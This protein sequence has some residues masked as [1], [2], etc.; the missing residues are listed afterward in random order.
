MI[1]CDFYHLCHDHVGEIVRK[2]FLHG[3]TWLGSFVCECSCPLLNCGTS[4]ASQDKDKE[5]NSFVFTVKAV[6]Q[7][8]TNEKA[9][10]YFRLWE[11]FPFYTKI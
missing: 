2:I 10:V 4:L 7:Q 8:A 1:D 3:R 9:T 5:V 6:K 11:I